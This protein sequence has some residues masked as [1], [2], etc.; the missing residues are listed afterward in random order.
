MP[1]ETE[2]CQGA[3]GIAR[4]WATLFWS[5]QFVWALAFVHVHFDRKQTGL[6]YFGIAS[7]LIVG[8]L[9]LKAYVAGVVL[10]PIGVGGACCEWGLALLFAW[11]CVGRQRSLKTE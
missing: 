9:L 7:K 4:M 2:Q 1:K 3:C 6:I 5:L 8:T 10:A 11:D